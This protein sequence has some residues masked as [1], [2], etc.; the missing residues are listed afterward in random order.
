[1]LLD[2]LRATTDFATG[3]SG[4]L[5]GDGGP[6]TGSAGIGGDAAMGSIADL[7]TGS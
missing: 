4:L 1:M 7:I 3:L 6:G 2:F 5:F